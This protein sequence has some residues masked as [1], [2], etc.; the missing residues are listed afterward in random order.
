MAVCIETSDGEQI[1]SIKSWRAHVLYGDRVGLSRLF[2][3]LSELAC[4]WCAGGRDGVPEEILALLE[5]GW[6]KVQIERVLASPQV[7]TGV[8]GA[9][10]WADLLLNGSTASGGL[11]VIVLAGN[12]A[13]GSDTPLVEINPT[14]ADDLTATVCGRRFFSKNGGPDPEF[15][16]IPSRLVL[17]CAAALHNAK[18]SGASVAAVVTHE[19]ETPATFR[20]D[21]RLERSLLRAFG[22]TIDI[23]DLQPGVLNRAQRGHAPAGDPQLWLGFCTRKM[24]ALAWVT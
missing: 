2:N 21:I 17:A 12:R 18:V 14:L 10:F 15:A 5:T 13:L 24:P 19:I 8:G 6:E 22:R 11:T 1:T 9:S 4:A 3:G 16:L 20:E 23:D 7:P